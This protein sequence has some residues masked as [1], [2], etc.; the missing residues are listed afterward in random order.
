MRGMSLQ[1]L[2][3]WLRETQTWLAFHFLHLTENKTYRTAFD[4]C[5][6]PLAPHLKMTVKNLG[7]LF[8]TDLRFDKQIS[9]VVES[10]FLQLRLLRKFQ[11]LLS[12]DF[13][14]SIHAFVSS[15][16]E[17][18]NALYSVVSVLPLLPSHGPKCF[19]SSLYK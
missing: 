19:Y 3:E 9:S 4:Q 8:D 11:S 10:R 2:F 17:Y 7:V 12:F 6:C 1:Q 14:I 15:R 13:E 18:S 16:L 5:Y